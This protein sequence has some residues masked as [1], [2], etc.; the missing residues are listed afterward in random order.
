MSQWRR[1][2]FTLVEILIVVVILGILAAI[3]TPQFANSA[4]ESRIN[5]TSYE[6][7]R[8]RNALEVY[9]STV[10]G[11][12]DITA[13]DG[14]WGEL[15]GSGDFLS[16]APANTWVGGDNRRVIA[17]DS[18]PDTGFQTSHGWIFDGFT[19]RVWAGGFDGSDRPFPKP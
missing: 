1:K 3:V 18:T 8:L 16:T 19:G 13:G 2:A 12:P 6:L 7:T 9:Y 15:V 10:G 4:D 5:T 11:F 14:T 17:L